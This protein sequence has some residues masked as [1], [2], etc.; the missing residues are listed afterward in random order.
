MLTPSHSPH[1]LDYSTMIWVDAQN[2]DAVAKLSSYKNVLEINKLLHTTV[3]Y[4][5]DVK[6]AIMEHL[7]FI[8]SYQLFERNTRNRAL[9]SIEEREQRHKAEAE[10]NRRVRLVFNVFMAMVW[11]HG[12]TKMNFFPLSNF[13]DYTGL[14]GIH[15]IIN[16]LDN[17]IRF[18]DMDYLEVYKQPHVYIHYMVVEVQIST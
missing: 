9:S 7:R 10:A 18:M 8:L 16:V 13:N 1:G 6:K 17:P 15:P 11:H 2:P 12:K 5:R 14:G 4:T 3:G